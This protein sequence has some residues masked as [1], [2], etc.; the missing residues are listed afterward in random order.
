MTK[1][2]LSTKSMQLLRN[3]SV[4]TERQTAVIRVAKPVD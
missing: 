3:V 1:T 4:R 2:V